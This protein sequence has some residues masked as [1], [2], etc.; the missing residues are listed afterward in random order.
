MV[1][2]IL[3][4]GMAVIL[5]ATL[6]ARGHAGA[7]GGGHGVAAA[8]AAHVGAPA[9]S[10]ARSGTRVVPSH[11]QVPI[12]TRRGTRVTGTRKQNVASARSRR[13]QNCNT[14]PGLGFDET[15]HIAV[16]GPESNGF[17]SAGFANGYYF[18]FYE[19]GFYMPGASGGTDD[20]TVA[21]A[22]PQNL[23]EGDSGDYGRRYRP[24]PEEQ[25]S[26][27]GPDDNSGYI[28]VRRDGTVFFAVAYSWE[29]GTLRYVTGEG[30]R[31]T[32]AED[33]LDLN[34][35][36]QFNEQRG[37]DFRLPV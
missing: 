31:R 32:I 3:L 36:K 16:C 24:Q 11:A 14:A 30:L 23:P 2:Q 19:G 35:T 10:G 17:R 9:V 37:F 15:H 26:Y 21:D 12:G 25:A 29:N 4:A 6:Q 13:P 22:N 1:R 18:P 7:S 28:F 33:A 20:N 8:P 5:P 34:A 27:A